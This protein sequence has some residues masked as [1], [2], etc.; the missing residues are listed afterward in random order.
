M[1]PRPDPYV[2]TEE[3]RARGFPPIRA[4]DIRRKRV[5]DQIMYDALQVAEAYRIAR[6]GEL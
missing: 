4:S 5:V 6:E 3:Q 2:F 1:N